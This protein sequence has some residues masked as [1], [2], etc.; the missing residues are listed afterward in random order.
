MSATIG[1]SCNGR[2]STVFRALLLAFFTVFTFTALPLAVAQSPTGADSVTAYIFK[3][4]GSQQLIMAKEIDKPRSPASLTKIMTC[5]LAIESGR[6]DE[7]V[8]IS[9]EASLVEPTVAGFKPGERFRLRDLVKAAMV[10]SSNDAAFAIAGYLGGGSVDLFVSLMNSRARAL[11]M[12][13]TYFTN[14]AG[15]DRGV[16]AGNQS[17]ARDLMILSERAIRYPEF[18]AIARLDMAVFS[19]LVSG[20]VYNLR[21]HNKLFDRYPYTIGIK[22]GYT[23]QAGPCLI[24]RAV[25]D[26]KDMLIIMLNARTDRWSLASSMFEQAVNPSDQMPRPQT[27]RV[28][29]PDTGA[30]VAAPAVASIA[31]RAKTPKALKPGRAVQKA[32]TVDRSG[33]AER[34]GRKTAAE[35]SSRKSRSGKRAALVAQKS[36]EKRGGKAKVAKGEK[37]ERAAKQKLV[38]SRE[39]NGKNR[40]ALKADRKGGAKSGKLASAQTSGKRKAVVKKEK[41]KEPKKAALKAGK[42]ERQA[43]GKEKGGASKEKSA[44]RKKKS[45][46]E[47]SFS[48]KPAHSPQG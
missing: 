47:L 46:E 39:R 2:E 12:S 6:M 37:K 11:G 19:E 14:P 24:A 23:S 42:K 21:T 48:K 9:E 5:M 27:Q 32:S 44:K 34:R 31:E 36:S 30:V 40:S 33:N 3:E 38:K 8:T 45:K 18:N 29:R 13:H 25:R 22:T 16:Y 4:T 41:G 1:V 10:N 20:K 26:G 35:V 7:V 28:S 43:V 15:Y 17:S